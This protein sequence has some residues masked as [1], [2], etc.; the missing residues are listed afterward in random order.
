MNTQKNKRTHTIYKKY[1]IYT[2]TQIQNQIFKYTE[3]L[4]LLDLLNKPVMR[5][6][7]AKLNIWTVSSSLQP[8]LGH[9]ISND[10]L[11]TL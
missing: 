3:A 1:T 11:L 10:E 6:I 9:L 2:N 8:G 5:R 7:S 4:L